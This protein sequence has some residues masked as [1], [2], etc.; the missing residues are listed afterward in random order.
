M[1]V[2]LTFAPEAQIRTLQSVL[3]S[4]SVQRIQKDCDESDDDYEG[5]EARK[6]DFDRS[7]NKQTSEIFREL[8][9]MIDKD[10]YK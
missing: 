5:T 6:T 10:P 1:L 8:Q 9:T 2:S 7:D 3:E 4:R